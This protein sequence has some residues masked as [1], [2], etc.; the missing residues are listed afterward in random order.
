VPL[1]PALKGGTYGA[2]A[3]QRSF[4]HLSHEDK[5]LFHNKNIFTVVFNSRE[6]S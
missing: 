3:G 4:S 2:L 6:L 5:K 1:D